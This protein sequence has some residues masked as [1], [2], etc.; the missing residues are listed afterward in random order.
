MAGVSALAS[1]QVDHVREVAVTS[2]DVV[3]RLPNAVLHQAITAQTGV[4]RMR[5]TEKP[6]DDKRVRQAIAAC[7]DH[8]RLLELAYRGRGAVGEDH[9]VAPIHP[10]YFKS[11]ALK[12]D[13]E[14]AKALLAEA[15][16][17]DGLTVKIDLGAAEAWHLA[18]MQGFKEQLAPAG[19]NLELN[20]MPGASYW[21]VW[22]KTPFGFTSWTHRPLGVMVLNLGYRGGVPWNESGYN[23]AEFDSALDE[24]SGTLDV[25]DRRAKM[26]KVQGILRDDAVIAQPLWRAIFSATNKK[27]K[28]YEIHP[29]FYHQFQKV[30]LA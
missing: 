26:E 5:V 15:G 9:H 16:H 12:P 11:A 22:D 30:W 8:A 28:G 23:S 1:G 19:I 17:G 2:I 6:F 3:E 29:T 10:E 20:L 7:M 4:A 14:K 27:V 18:A 25:N 13:I 24:A 21:D